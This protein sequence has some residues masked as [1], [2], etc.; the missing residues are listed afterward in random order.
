MWIVNVK[1]KLNLSCLGT[2]ISLLIVVYVPYLQ[3]QQNSVTQA[4]SETIFARIDDR[5]IT[6]AEFSSIFRA[7]VRHKYYHGRVPEAELKKFKKQVAQDTV[8]QVLL[9]REA[10]KLGIKPNHEKIQKGLVDYDSK[11]ANSVEWNDQK[12]KVKPL[13]IDRLERQD[14]IEKMQLRVNDIDI[15]DAAKVKQYYLQN[16]QKFT[17]P[18]RLWL[19]VILL[20]VPP[21]SGKKIWKD[22]EQA[23][24]QFKTRAQNGAVFSA[25][26]RQYSAHPSAV[27]GGDLGY[28]HQGM[29]DGDA[30]RAVSSLKIN[31][32]SDPVFVLEG[33]TLFR[34]N[35]IQAEKLK[36]FTEVA[37]RAEGLLHRELKDNAWDAYT[38]ALI[39]TANISINEDLY[40]LNDD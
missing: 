22:A 11:Y 34:L 31:E 3:A 14:L 2:V 21:S 8:L 12:E 19:S 1:T 13:L 6:Q 9:H 20:E 17:E 7:A 23:A 40:V 5:T 10:L 27:N 35:G 36:P 38:S 26:A 30:Q 37:K 18:R 15:P 32:L 4:V 33:I 24:L 16:L 29:L 28:L 25:L 39:N